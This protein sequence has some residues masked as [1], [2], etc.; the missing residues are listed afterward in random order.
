MELAAVGTHAPTDAQHYPLTRARVSAS[1]SGKRAL[2]FS[3]PCTAATFSAATFCTPVRVVLAA[4]ADACGALVNEAALGNAIVL[5]RRGGCQFSDKAINVQVGRLLLR[6]P[7][8]TFLFCRPSWRH[9]GNMGV[10]TEVLET[11]LSFI[12]QKGAPHVL[13]PGGAA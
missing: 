11:H 5:A 12:L 3:F 9:T 7:G 8:I 6:P 2:A 4:P 1:S 10:W 13:T